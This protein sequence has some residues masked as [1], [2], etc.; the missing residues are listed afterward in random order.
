LAN[1]PKSLAGKPKRKTKKDATLTGDP[2]SIT[3]QLLGVRD[4]NRFDHMQGYTA[5]ER[6]FLQKSPFRF[7][8][9]TTHGSRKG[10][11]L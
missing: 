10:L 8:P 4:A 5:P 9:A 7:R 2:Q 11:V 6:L 3:Q 1:S